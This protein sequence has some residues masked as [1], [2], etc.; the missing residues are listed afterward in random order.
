MLFVMLSGLGSGP[1]LTRLGQE[2]E[3]EEEVAWMTTCLRAGG[4]HGRLKEEILRLGKLGRFIVIFVN[5]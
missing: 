3:E 1:P 4:E 2:E 5:H